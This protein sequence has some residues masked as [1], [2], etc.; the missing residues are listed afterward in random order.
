[1]PGR[2][3][4]EILTGW[5]GQAGQFGSTSRLAQRIGQ[6]NWGQ[7]RELHPLEPTARPRSLG[8]VPYWAKDIGSM[9]APRRGRSGKTDEAS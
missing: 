4:E 3:A 7:S 8:K 1:M 9:P 6:G 5:R 2:L